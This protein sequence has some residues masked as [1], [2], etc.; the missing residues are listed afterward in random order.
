M[1]NQHGVPQTSGLVPLLFDYDDVMQCGV[2]WKI[3]YSVWHFSD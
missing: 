3:E 1:L 2:N